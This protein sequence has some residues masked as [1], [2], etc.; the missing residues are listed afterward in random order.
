[1][2]VLLSTKSWEQIIELLLGFIT[3]SVCFQ[4]EVKNLRVLSLTSLFVS[5]Q[6]HTV[7]AKFTAESPQTPSSFLLLQCGG[8]DLLR[9]FIE[10]CPSLSFEVPF[11]EL[12]RDFQEGLSLCLRK[13]KPNVEGSADTDHKEWDVAEM[14]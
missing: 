3:S 6:G 13:E 12:L 1:M 2:H 10:T 7:T 4:G 11:P 14:C 8:F 5:L 9:A